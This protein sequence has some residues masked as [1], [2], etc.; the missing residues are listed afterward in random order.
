MLTHVWI[1]PGLMVLSF[2]VILFF[3]K[4][5]SERVTSGI[6]IFFIAVCFVLSCLTSV[7]WIQRINHPVPNP[8]AAEAVV[9]QPGGEPAPVGGQT[10]AEAVLGAYGGPEEAAK[11]GVE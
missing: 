6:G 8:T 4:R 3:G 9:T 1:I 11:D 7:N 10:D 2:L 5:F